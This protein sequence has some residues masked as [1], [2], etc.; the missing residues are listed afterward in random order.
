MLLFLYTLVDP[1]DKYKIE[2]IYQTFHDDMI[3]LARSKLK[4]ANMSNYNYDAEDVVQNAFVKITKYIKKID[5]HV[6]PIA[7]RAYIFTIVSNEAN[8]F[9]QENKFF[10][11]IDDYAEILQDRPDEEFMPDGKVQAEYQNM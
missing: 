8:S 11:S 6:N 10:E 9:M 5:I 2:Y 7:L 4:T 3:R 1:D